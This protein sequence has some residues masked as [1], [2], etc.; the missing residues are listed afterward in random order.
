MSEIPARSTAVQQLIEQYTSPPVDMALRDAVRAASLD[1]AVLRPARLRE[2]MLQIRGKSTVPVEDLLAARYG[3]LAR[4]YPEMGQQHKLEHYV[5]PGQRVGALRA[6]TDLLGKNE[7]LRDNVTLVI[8]YEQMANVLAQAAHTVSPAIARAPKGAWTPAREDELREA[9]RD[10]T[11][12]RLPYAN[13]AYTAKKPRHAE[14]MLGSVTQ[15]GISW[16]TQMVRRE[17]DNREA[18][19]PFFENMLSMMEASENALVRYA[20]EKTSQR[21]QDGVPGLPGH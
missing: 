3:Q 11:V 20:R 5:D 10:A 6:A 18:R 16:L 12:A 8:A 14:Q 9:F 15:D 17:V 4:N 7:P 13:P 19:E 2:D 21:G 1:P